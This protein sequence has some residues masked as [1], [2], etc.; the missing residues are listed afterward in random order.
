DVYVQ[1]GDIVKGG[2]QDRV[3]TTDF[4]LPAHSGKLPISSFCVEQGRWTKR[5]AESDAQFSASANSVP[6]KDLKLAVKKAGA[7]SEVWASVAQARM[8]LS[9]P[10][11]PPA[12]NRPATA[13][14][15]SAGLASSTSMQLALESK[16]VVDATEAYV[17]ALSKIVDTRPDVA[18]YVYAINGEINSAEVYASPELFRQMW[19]KLLRASATEALAERPKAKSKTPPTAADV[20]TA[21]AD[22]DRANSSSRQTAGRSTVTRKESAKVVVFETHDSKQGSNW[23]HR[24]YVV[25]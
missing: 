21:L 9:V 24:S 13:A 22:A 16:P 8:A 10:A 2:R 17:K 7:Q 1:S 20:K 18:G 15:G 11:A 25:K 14:M 4:I 19:P 3:L 6:S 5:G 12:P 23:I